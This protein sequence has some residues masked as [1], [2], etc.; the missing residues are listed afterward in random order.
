[1]NWNAQLPN[2]KAALSNEVTL[3][4]DLQFVQVET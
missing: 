4:A 3:L 1:M 2:G